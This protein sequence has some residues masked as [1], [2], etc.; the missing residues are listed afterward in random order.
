MT[1]IN[2]Q[3]LIL[4]KSIEEISKIKIKIDENNQIIEDLEITEYQPNII[5][6][7][8]EK[9]N[10]NN[11]YGTVKIL[12]TDIETIQINYNNIPENIEKII[13][14]GEIIENK[15]SDI[16]G[17]LLLRATVKNNEELALIILERTDININIEN[18]NG[19]TSLIWACYNKMA[20]VAIKILQRQEIKIKNNH[21][22]ILLSMCD[23]DIMNNVKKILKLK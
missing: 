3:Y 10:Y 8:G 9:V 11:I 4:D 18:K 15:I 23:T 6:A 16:N 14:S 13:I 22:I 20:C 21:K 2:N 7:Y 17:Y 12:I 19:F 1:Y 5:I